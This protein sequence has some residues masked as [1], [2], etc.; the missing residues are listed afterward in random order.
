MTIK[1][2]LIGLAIST[3]SNEKTDAKRLDII[4]KSLQS[5]EEYIKTSNLNLYIVV[6]VDGPIPSSHT[7]II[8]EKKFNIYLRKRNGGV[9]KTKNTCIKIL[10]E[11]EVDIGILCD[12]DV[13]YKPNCIEKYVETMIKCNLH[14]M[15]FCQMPELVHPK[16]E[17]SK[18]GYIQTQI[19]NINIM[20]HG[21][22]GVGC[23]LTFTKELIDKIGYFKILSGK[24]GYEHINF[25]HRCIYHNMIPFV[26]D[27]MNS[28][29]Y[30]DHIGFEPV[31]Y[32]KFK[33]IHSID[34]EYRVQ[35]NNKNK[36][37][38]KND[39][40]TLIDCIE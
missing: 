24:Y 8:F 18:M 32:N 6:V 14:H 36:Y 27:I 2:D 11:K 35:E 15:S 4:N 21:G 33:K 22:G 28:L 9:A 16:N 13:I 20:K 40:N 19:N 17:W 3:Y 25:T 12:D 38:W 10:L 26:S 34:E 30:I 39:L 29:D 23:L 31:G 1:N 7:K 5:L 37:E